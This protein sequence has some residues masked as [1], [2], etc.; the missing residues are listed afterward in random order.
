MGISRN[1]GLDLVL[2]E[3]FLHSNGRSISL[4]IINKVK[5]RKNMGNIWLFAFFLVPLQ[6]QIAKITFI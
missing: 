5:E 4:Y 6:P 1:R 3:Y 2:C